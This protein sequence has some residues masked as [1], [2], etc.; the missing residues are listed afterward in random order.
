[1]ATSVDG[2][3]RLLKLRDAL[4][5]WDPIGLGSARN[6]VPEEYDELAQALSGALSNHASEAAIERLVVR[7]IEDWGVSGR[8][9]EQ[10]LTSLQVEMQ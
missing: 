9:L 6:E 10:F 4:W 2:K 8:G 7:Q 3:I 1:M 5:R